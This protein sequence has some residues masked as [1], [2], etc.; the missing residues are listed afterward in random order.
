VT[1]PIEELAN[2]GPATARRLAEIGVRDEADLRRMGA[3]QAYARLRFLFGKI[4]TL[5]TLYALDAGLT[6]T[7]WRAM[8]EARKRRLR[9]AA[10][11]APNGYKESI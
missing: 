3:V 5:N 6:D 10:G 11:V 4:I 2:L 9:R 7:H 8:T 1:R